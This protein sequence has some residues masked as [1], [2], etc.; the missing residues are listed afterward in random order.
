MWEP[1]M[2]LTRKI[3]Q[4]VNESQLKYNQRNGVVIQKFEQFR[5]TFLP[6]YLFFIELFVVLYLERFKIDRIIKQ[7]IILIALW[8]S[9][10]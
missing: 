8:R 4:P 2:E 5:N 1:R 9:H 6:I 10:A 3:I 7:F